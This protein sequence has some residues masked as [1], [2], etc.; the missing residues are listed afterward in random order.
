MVPDSNTKK[1]NLRQGKSFNPGDSR[2]SLEVKDRVDF[3]CKGGAIKMPTGYEQHKSR[4][5]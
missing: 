1:F 2:A 4:R 3:I 5:S